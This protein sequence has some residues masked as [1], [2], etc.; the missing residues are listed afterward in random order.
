MITRRLKHIL[1]FASILVGF[2][3]IAYPL[4]AVRAEV[5]PKPALQPTPFLT[6]TPRQDGKIIYIVKVGDS[7]W[8]I[9]AIASITLE[10][11]MAMNGIQ[12]GDYITE[13][14]ELELGVGGPA[15]ATAAPG[16]AQA[17]P[18]QELLT[19]T[20]VVGT[21]EI[22]ILLFMDENGNG[23]LEEGELPLAG[24]QISI[25]DV[26][27]IVAGEVTTE[28][29]NEEDPV[30]HCFPEL[31]NGDYNVSAAVP[32]EYNPT[33]GLNVPVTL[34]PGDIKYLQFGAQPSSSIGGSLNTDDGGRSTVLGILGVVLLLS[35]GALGYYASRM[36]RRTPRSLR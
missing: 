6:P 14:M 27:G 34:K 30:G 36:S 16:D 31:T 12:P 26:N 2:L 5:S 33:T 35:A 7:L 21:A 19:P 1:L 11:L 13:G 15:L 8:R 17:T 32:P 4:A 29:L 22:C 9:A 20:P 3:W 24:G 25:V 28:D 10:E 23:R 18:T